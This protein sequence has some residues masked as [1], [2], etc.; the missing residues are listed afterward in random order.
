[1]LAAI[2]RAWLLI[3]DHARYRLCRVTGRTKPT[4]REA[5]GL[6][7]AGQASAFRAGISDWDHGGNP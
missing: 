7:E 3:P 1:M 4:A 2:V 6:L 5:L